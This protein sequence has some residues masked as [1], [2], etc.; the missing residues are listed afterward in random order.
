MNLLQRQFPWSNLRLSAFLKGTIVMAHGSLVRGIE[1]AL[2]TT[3]HHTHTYMCCK[4]LIK[5]HLQCNGTFTLGPPFP[6]DHVRCSMIFLS[7]RRTPMP[8]QRVDSVSQFIDGRKHSMVVVG[9]WKFYQMFDLTLKPEPS[10]NNTT[11]F[12]SSGFRFSYWQEEYR[13]SMAQSHIS[14]E[15]RIIWQN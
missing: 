1:A 5:I 10:F 8:D 3:T 13:K 12:N 4:T 15:D 6:S 11:S 14:K 7:H 9:F 2:T